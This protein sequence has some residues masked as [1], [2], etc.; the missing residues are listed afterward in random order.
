VYFQAA[1]QAPGE[2]HF[3]SVKLD[4]SEL[5]PIT[6][7][8][9]PGYY[10][11]KFSTGAGYGLLHYQGPAVPWQRLISVPA[12]QEASYDELLEEN[13]R[14]KKMTRTHAMPLLVYSNVTIDGFTLPVVE[15]RPPNFDPKKKYPVLFHLY[16]GP[17]SQTVSRQFSVGFQTYV[18]SSLE[19]LVVT[20]DGRGTGFIGRRARCIIRDNLG[21]YE[22]RD[23]IE[24]AK[25][26]GRKPYVD[27]TRMAIW[28]WSYGGYM[29]L[30]TLEQDAGRT[31]QYGMAV[32]PVTDW[33]FYGTQPLSSV[34]F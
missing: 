3:Y 31:F 7:I 9:E 6:N 16:G 33:Q 26:W 8:S 18:A 14:L 17:G 1:K 23:Q 12:N 19:Y 32:A 4:G 20:V 10:G 34:P 15:M 5:Q 22:A 2:R 21:H 30:K 13:L 27:K 24:T 25:I 29:T 11:L 28:G